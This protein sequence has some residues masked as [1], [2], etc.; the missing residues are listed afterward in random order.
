MIVGTRK[1]KRHLW[2]LAAAAAALVY[3]LAT[4]NGNG[5][6][7]KAPTIATVERGPI[8]AV[9]SSTGRVVPDLDVEIKCKASGEVKALPF[10]V[11]DVVT[12]GALLVELDPIDE[13]RRVQ[14]AQIALASSRARVEQKRSA[15]AVA[16]RSLQTNR[17]RAQTALESAKARAAD[18]RAKA[19]RSKLLLQKQ[20]LS[21]EEFDTVETS[22]V[23]AEAEL[24]NARTRL[25]ELETEALSLEISRQDLQLASAQVKSDEITLAD[26][27]RRLSET[28][29]FAPI[30]GVISG[31]SV[32]I[33]QIVSSGINNIGGGTTLMTVA[34]LRRIYVLASVDESD[35]GSVEVGHKAT[36]TVD[37]FPDETFRGTVT[38]IATK[39][40]N[41]S[42]VVTFEV[43]VEVTDERKRLLK[44]EM[45]AN[46][47]IVTASKESAL[48][49]PAQAISKGRRGFVAVV[50]S[51]DGKG[52]GERRP[53]TIGI[54][55]DT[56]IEIVE[57]LA[58]G[59][60]VQL[61]NDGAESKWRSERARRGPFGH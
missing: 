57:G 4:R 7:V 39:G 18:A 53:V 45:T 49:V 31:R 13:Q 24:K 20:L 11:S 52:E 51:P 17:T 12:Q 38:R 27:Q 37:A 2:I 60:R 3:W 35:I 41:V 26:A 16:E 10:D 47:D 48:L 15:L 61:S 33:G 23:Q 28:K 40:V 58:E 42:N 6:E 9:V 14:Q 50:P 43:K 55:N 32:E 21:Q 44:P 34:D 1:R 19:E 8:T 36:I 5:T 25:E 56:T 30:D 46:V 59:D 22:A 54:R 29:V